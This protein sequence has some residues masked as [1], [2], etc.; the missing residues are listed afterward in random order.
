MAARPQHSLA[1]YQCGLLHTLPATLHKAGDCWVPT[2]PAHHTPDGA[3]G[4]PELEIASVIRRLHQKVLQKLKFISCQT[5]AAAGRRIDGNS[6][7]RW[8]HDPTQAG[9]CHA[10]QAG[11]MSQIG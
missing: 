5:P 3:R 10:R 11:R 4:A 9:T 2:A 6:T 8:A 7:L 1:G